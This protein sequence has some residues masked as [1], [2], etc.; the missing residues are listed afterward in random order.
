MTFEL[1]IPKR[2]R[3]D[4]IARAEISVAKVHP[5][6]SRRQIDVKISAEV[7]AKAG[8]V[9][10]DKV[11]VMRDKNSGLVRL[12]KDA[13]RSKRSYTLSAGGLKSDSVGKALAC[14]VRFDAE[15]W[16]FA[17]PEKRTP[18][19]FYAVSRVGQAAVLDFSW[20]IFGSAQ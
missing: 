10:G 3:C 17:L 18:V 5:T 12:S 1:V 9:C 20:P 11:F 15:D 19:A 16:P 4:Q 14:S 7:L 6:N 2:G 13:D 8:W